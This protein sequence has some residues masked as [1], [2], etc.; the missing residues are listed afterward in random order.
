M[1]FSAFKNHKECLKVILRH[2]KEYNLPKEASKYS[3][4]RMADWINMKTDEDFTALHFSSYHGNLE[5]II[6]LVDDLHA[7]I[8]VRNIYGANVL[9]I[10][11]QGD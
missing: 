4:K 6:E 8:K 5:L 1:A 11:A 7:D 3:E 9:H 10:A 2:A